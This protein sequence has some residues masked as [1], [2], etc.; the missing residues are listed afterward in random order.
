MTFRRL[1]IVLSALTLLCPALSAQE[2]KQDSDSLFWLIS[3]R[4]ASLIEENG[5]NFRKVIGPARFFHNN[6]YLLCDTALWNVTSSVIYANGHVQIIQDR[7]V[8]SSET[9]EYLIDEDL[10]KFRGD[11]VQLEDKDKNTLRTRYLDY[12]TKDSVAV[13]Q[14]GASMRDKDGQLIE[15]RFGSY[16]SKEKTFT[17]MDNVNMFTDS[18][19]IKTSRLEYKSGL[20]K[21]F[22]GYGTDAWEHENMLSADDG[23]YDRGEE[24]FFFR[25]KVHIHSKNNEGWCDS[26]YFNRVTEDVEMLGN[27]EVMDTTRN[28]YALAG[29]LVYTDSLSRIKMTR[30]PAV[31]SI[32]ENGNT[33][34]RDTL[35]FGADT[36]V[37]MTVPRCAVDS[38]AVRDAAKRVKTIGTDAVA[39]YRRK[40]AEEAAKAMEEAKKKKEEANRP[41][42][43]KK[44]ETAQTDTSGGT[45]NESGNEEKGEENGEENGNGEA[46]GGESVLPPADTLRPSADTLRPP[47]DTLRASADSLRALSDTL[48]ARSDT[49]RVSADSLKAQADTLG[50]PTDS[51]KAMPDSLAPKKPLEPAD[52]TGIGFMWAVKNVRLFRSDIQM[53]CDSLAYT[54]LDSLV[55]MYRSPL[56]FNENGTRQYAADSL[57]VIVE[58]QTVKRANLMSNAFIVTQEDT[59]YYDQIRGAEVVAYFDDKRNLQRF[60]ALG[61]ATALFFLEENG[62]L[63]T[64]NRVESKMLYATFSN[65]NINRIYYFDNGK[66][67]AY[68]IVQLPKEQSLLKG[69]AWTPEKRPKGKEDVTSLVPRKSERLSYEAR[70]KAK[71][72]FTEDYF[73]GYIKK[74]HDEI[75]KRDTL[76][77]RRERERRIRQEEM[78]RM[79]RDSTLWA[80]PSDTLAK[81]DSLSPAKDT[82]VAGKDSLSVGKTPLARTD[83]LT[84]SVPVVTDSMTTASKTLT[85][86]ERKERQKQEKKALREAK[87]KER[88]AAREARWAKSDEKYEARQEAKRQKALQKERNRKLKDLR[89]REKKAAKEKKRLEQYI[90]R[91]RKQQSRRNP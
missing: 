39:E 70:P 78:E 51:L 31:M 2:K 12:N 77:A 36:L 35:Y 56:V 50:A 79:K 68:P 42:E 58:N 59:L 63:A 65:G 44:Q 86:A 17:F 46:P 28:V 13:F 24:L 81:A 29:R 75:A 71:F 80:V 73:P 21:A 5:Q 45:E 85:E 10:A 57:Y 23:W 18:I 26:L 25:K 83:S 53:A 82:L 49:L 30:D 40:A 89:K 16:D 55:R 76:A 9:L 54:D 11:L 62:T 4:S 84:K 20:N 27:A 6:T 1:A 60:D 7:T 33:R 32:S 3:A 90:E 67:D 47:A 61:G 41:P 66:N 52:S 19:F 74:V 69:F 91:L 22:F 87:K 8:L 88:E 72:P 43:K 37:Y 15:S 38:A 34:Q 14:N 64:V 48:L